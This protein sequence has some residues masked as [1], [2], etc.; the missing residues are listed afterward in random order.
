MSHGGATGFK[1]PP[2][3]SFTRIAGNKSLASTI[4]DR[5]GRADA[6]G[7]S[8]RSPAILALRSSRMPGDAR[9]HGPRQARS[10][11]SQMPEQVWI[12]RTG[13]PRPTS[14]SWATCGDP[15]AGPGHAVLRT[16]R[17]G[18]EPRDARAQRQAVPA[19]RRRHQPR[20]GRWTRRSSTSTP[21]QVPTQGGGEDEGVLDHVHA[22]GR[23]DSLSLDFTSD[24]SMSQDDIL[25]YIVTGRPASDNPLFESSGPAGIPVSRWPSEPGR[26]DLERRGPGPGARRVPD[27]AGPEPRAHPDR[28]PIRRLTPVHESPAS[29]SG[30]QPEPADAGLESRAR[31]R[32]GVHAPALASRRCSRREPRAGL[33][34]R[35][36]RAY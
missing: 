2:G 21:L 9:P 6:R 29:A 28:G 1:P 26:R 33:P 19:D 5:A 27:P 11:T 30:R 22:R 18:A 31:L 32:A 36:R 10:G 34:V 17:A 8:G 13:S 4:L 3:I 24:P 7:S 23:L 15:A 12:R 14:S 35:G 16:R 20:P 25:S